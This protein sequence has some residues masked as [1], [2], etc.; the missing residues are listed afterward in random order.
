M[1]K[2]SVRPG[3][4]PRARPTGAPQSPRLQNRFRSGTSGSAITAERGS[5][6]GTSGT[7][8]S[9]APRRCRP[10]EDV[11][12]PEL[13][14]DTERPEPRSDSER[15]SRPETDR[16][17]A[18]ERDARTERA[19][20]AEPGESDERGEPGE[21]DEREPDDELSRAGPLI[22]LR[23]SPVA[24]VGCDRRAPLLATTGASP[25]VPQ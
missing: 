16:R 6:R 23:P 25:Q 12:E 17:D 9:P 7:E 18:D 1:Q 14:T 21:P 2:P 8:T 24:P 20:R 11:E 5:G 13:R 15:D 10:D 22:T 3:R 4:S 19:E